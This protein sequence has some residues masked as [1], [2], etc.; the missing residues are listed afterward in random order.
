[1]LEEFKMIDSGIKSGI[2]LD[3]KIFIN[4]ISDM[5]RKGICAKVECYLKRIL[6]EHD[7]LNQHYKNSLWLPLIKNRKVCVIGRYY[8]NMVDIAL[9]QLI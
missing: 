8:N 7:G 1:M 4:A 5:K 2:N 9:V 3:W 6:E